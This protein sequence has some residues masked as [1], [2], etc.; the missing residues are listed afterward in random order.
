MNNTRDLIDKADKLLADKS[1]E[2]AKTEYQNAI[3]IKPAETYPKG[4]RLK[5]LTIQLAEIAKKKALDDQYTFH[6][7]QCR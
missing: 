1:Y 2:P 7:C 5:R 3:A 4:Q 6:P